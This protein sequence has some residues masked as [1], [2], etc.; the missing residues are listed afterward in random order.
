M[1]DLKKMMQEA[2][3]AADEEIKLK[4]SRSMNLVINSIM[5]IERDFIYGNSKQR[6]PDVK[7]VIVKNYKKILEEL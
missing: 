5:K 4:N 3:S 6:K 7:S 2:E 1:F